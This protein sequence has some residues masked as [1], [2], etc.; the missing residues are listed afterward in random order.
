MLWIISYMPPLYRF[1][2]TGFLALCLLFP[3]SLH[4][5]FIESTI[6]TAVVNDATAVYLNPA[7]LTL[8]NNAQVIGLASMADFETNFTGTTRQALTGFTQSGTSHNQTHYFLPSI[9][10]GIP[11]SDNVVFGLAVVSN[12]FNRELDENSILR[13]AQA[14]NSVQ[15]VDLV[16]AVG[17][18]LN[19]YVSIGANINFSTASFVLEPT[20]GFPG[21]TPDSQSH[22]ESRG[23]SLGG[24]AGILVNVSKSTLVGF[25]YRSANTYREKGTSFF[26]GY[27]PI[28][29]DN[30]HFK[31]W[32]PAR[33][34]L[35]INQFITPKW[36]LIATLQRISWSIIN[37]V[38]TYGLATQIGS[39]SVILPKAS[40]PYHLNDAW[41]VTLGTHYR[42]TPKWIFRIAGT[43]NQ[44][45]GD[46]AYQIINGD[47]LI[48]GGSFGYDLTKN[49]ALDASYAHAFVNSANI[50]IASRMNIINGINRASRDSI[51]LKITIKAN[52]K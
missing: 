30:Y 37:Q 23:R 40:V 32:T 36:G 10:I 14:N 41:L 4:A 38:T 26:D 31:F 13:Y 11:S 34:V 47:S 39:R 46:S 8:I 29:S 49:I 12:F 17:I 1:V 45:T 3:L 9:Y 7:A 5:S 21:N 16:P 2:Q 18:K 44:A 25:N 28:L 52:G 51:S 6:G 20:T 15:N 43:Y 50:H 35:S 24:D 42:L 48:V 33:S 22:N 19:K 27:P